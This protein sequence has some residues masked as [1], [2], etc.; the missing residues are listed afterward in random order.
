MVIVQ[1]YPE[2]LHFSPRMA[3]SWRPLLR[4]ADAA[5]PADGTDAVV[6]IS[7]VP[8][9][10]HAPLHVLITL[11]FGSWSWLACTC[12]RFGGCSSCRHG[13]GVV[14]LSAIESKRLH[15]TRVTEAGKF[16]H[17]PAAGVVTRLLAPSVVHGSE[18]LQGVTRRLS[19]TTLLK[20]RCSRRSQLQPARG[21][22]LQLR[23]TM[24]SLP[25]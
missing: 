5:T 2:R 25:P 24:P 17:K 20:C 19:R 21:A 18:H 11:L 8:T 16:M 3:A 23:R 22:M 14:R 7:G 12:V 13:A 15:D 6:A 9:Q 4:S 1:H 10:R